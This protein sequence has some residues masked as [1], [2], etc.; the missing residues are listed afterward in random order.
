MHIAVNTAMSQGPISPWRM[1]VAVMDSEAPA[2]P[3]A[4]TGTPTASGEVKP[5]SGFKMK[6]I[7]PASIGSRRMPS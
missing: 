5:K 3:S 7:F 1:S 6:S 2:A 4:V